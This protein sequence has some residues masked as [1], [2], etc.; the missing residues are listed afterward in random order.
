[1]SKQ[2]RYPEVIQVRVPRGVKRVLTSH[3]PPD[4][5][6]YLRRYL[7]RLAKKKGWVS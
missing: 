4:L 6:T 2:L 3:C 5:A 7:I 1:M